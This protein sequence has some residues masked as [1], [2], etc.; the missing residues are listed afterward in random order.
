MKCLKQVN[1]EIREVPCGNWGGKKGQLGAMF[2]R[3]VVKKHLRYIDSILN[4]RQSEYDNVLNTFSQEIEHYHSYF[5]FYRYF[6][7]KY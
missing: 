1:S 6:A 2:I 4:V 5:E 7:Q 3:D